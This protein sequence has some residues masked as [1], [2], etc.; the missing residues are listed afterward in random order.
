MTE[1]DKQYAA[2][3]RIVLE[4]IR[5]FTGKDEKIP[6]L[7]LKWLTLFNY[8]VVC[9]VG[10]LINMFIIQGIVALLPLWQADLVAILAAFL[11]NWMNSVGPLGQYWDLSF[12]LS[13]KNKVRLNQL[14]KN[15]SIAQSKKLTA[16]DAVSQLLDG[17]ENQ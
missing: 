13:Q 17:R 10:V 4:V 14:A 15:L 8:A 11:W 9:G 12:N 1:P 7:Y 16:N 2:F 5:V 3:T 6:N